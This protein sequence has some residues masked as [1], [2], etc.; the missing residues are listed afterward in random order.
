[1]PGRAAEGLPWAPMVWRHSLLAV[2]AVL[3]ACG[4]SASG[5][6]A[7]PKPAPS[8]TSDQAMHA[9]AQKMSTV[10][11]MFSATLGSWVECQATHDPNAC[12][13]AHAPGGVLQFTKLGSITPPPPAQAAHAAVIAALNEVLQV[14]AAAEPNL[15]TVAQ[16]RSVGTDYL[17]A[18]QQLAAVCPDCDGGDAVQRWNAGM[19]RLGG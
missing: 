14:F 6:G 18:M 13:S 2:C 5:G 12:E 15:P 4:S 19:Q 9:Y 16:M 10:V 7:S 8:A 17:A 3:A 1:M 11:L